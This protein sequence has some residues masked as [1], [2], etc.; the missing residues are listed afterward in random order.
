M[1]FFAFFSLSQ[2]LPTKVCLSLPFLDYLAIPLSRFK[3]F[4][5]TNSLLLVFTSQLCKQSLSTR[6]SSQELTVRNEHLKRQTRTSISPEVPP[7]RL[8][9]YN[10]SSIANNHQ[11]GYKQGQ[12]QLLPSLSPPLSWQT[13][14]H[15][16]LTLN[17][18]T[19]QPGAV[20]PRYTGATGGPTTWN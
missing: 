3:Q 8:I 15:K 9:E 5:K 11:D 2:Y 6:W 19:P 12:G 4:K 10:S 17:F 18:I 14:T 7:P 16:V 13:K 1:V 20:P